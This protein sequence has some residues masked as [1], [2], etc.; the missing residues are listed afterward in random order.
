M[1]LLAIKIE[2]S[3]EVED[4]LTF[5]AEN[6][7]NALGTEVRKRSDFE[8]AGWGKDSTVV[9]LNEIK[10]LPK[11]LEFIAY[12]D[13]EADYQLLIKKIK[14]KLQELKSYGLNI[15]PNEITHYYIADQDWNTVWQKY[16]HVINFSRHLALVPEWENYTPAFSDQQ[17][18]KLNPGLAFGTG[19]HTT[20]QLVLMGLERILVKPQSVLDLGTGSGI[21]AI[22]AS[23]LGATKVLATDISDESITAAN[24]NIALNNLTNIKVKKSNLL[25]DVSGKYNIILANILAEILLDLIPDL[26]AHLDKDG[27]AIFSGI[28]YLQLDKIKQAL[29]QNNFEIE[30]TMRQDRWVSVIICRKHN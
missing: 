16:Y 28:D 6:D 1:K 11:D 30:I 18:I 27:K 23:K 22:A 19:G 3:H 8:Q 26:D 25:K 29:K 20:T 5:F 21:L 9:K 7:L 15:A 24:E 13:E 17:I 12:F 4:A 2:T 14:A 10:N